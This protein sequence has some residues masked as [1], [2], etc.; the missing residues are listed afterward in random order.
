MQTRSMSR[1]R[2]NTVSVIH[3]DVNIVLHDHHITANTSNETR[4]GKLT[5]S[6]AQK[7]KPFV[8]NEDASNMGLYYVPPLL[9]PKY[10][11]NIDFDDA[12]EMWVYNKKRKGNGC[13]SYKCMA[14]TKAGDPC[15]RASYLGRNYCRIHQSYPTRLSPTNYTAVVEY[16]DDICC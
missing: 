15:V 8:T 6:T 13:Y 5:R 10:E 11:V 2:R 7:I 16:S 1:R 3:E 14:F 4:L 9:E 12:H